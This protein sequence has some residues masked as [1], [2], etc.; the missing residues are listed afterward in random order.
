MQDWFESLIKE[1]F[2]ESL[3]DLYADIAS[4]ADDKIKEKLQGLGTKTEPLSSSPLIRVVGST[5]DTN[6]EVDTITLLIRGRIPLFK[7][8][9]SVFMRIELTIST[10][11]DIQN[12]DP[13]I[14]I[15]DWHTIIGDLKISKKNV[16]FANLGFGYNNDTWLGRGA[17]KII[18]AGFG[19]D[20]YLGGW[21]QQGVMIGFTMDYPVALPLGST[22]LGIKGVG[23]DFAY[24]FI[25][26]LEDS[27]VEVPNPTAEDYITW[28]RDD[29]PINRWQEGPI[30]DTSVGVG[31][32]AD[33][34]TLADQ[35]KALKLEPIGLMV[36]TP[37]PIFVLGGEGK[38]LEMQSAQVEGYIAVD[39]LS[40]SMALGLG[41]RFMMPPPKLGTK[42]KKGEKYIVDAQGT[43]D[44]FFSFAN[45]DAWYINLGSKEN[46][47]KAKT[48]VDIFRAQFYLMLNNY[49]VAVG[50]GISYGGQY[51]WWKITLTARIGGDVAA[52][53]GWN[54]VLFEGMLGIWAELG[55]KIWKFKFSL[56][57][58]V[59]VWGY[60][61]DPTRLEFVFKYKLDLP[62]PLPDY[63]GKK[64]YSIG[65]EDPKPPEI[66]SPLLAGESTVDNV[67]TQGALPI[68]L[69]HPLTGRQWEVG[70]EEEACWPDSVIVVPFSCRVV[71]ETPDKVVE[72]GLPISSPIEG[73][74]EVHHEMTALQVLHFPEGAEFGTPIEDLKAVWQAGP[75]GDIAQLHIGGTDPFSWVA[76]HPGVIDNTSETPPRVVEQNF[77]TG[78]PESF[79]SEKRFGEMIVEPIGE[80]DQLITDFYP[81]LPTRVMGGKNFKLKFKTHLNNPIEVEKIKL[82]FVCDPEHV[83]DISMQTGILEQQMVLKSI[84]GHLELRAKTFKVD[85]ASD[86]ISIH[87]LSDDPILLFSVRYQEADMVDCDLKDKLV[88]SP[89]TYQIKLAGESKAVYS[90]TDPDANLPD[91]SKVNWALSEVFNVEPPDTLRP[92]I[93]TTTIGD[94]RIFD[95]DSPPREPAWN[96]TM[97]GFGFP[98][99]QHYHPSVRFKVPYIDKIFQKIT[100]TIKYETGEEVKQQLT[101]K[102]NADGENYLPEMS[103][104]WIQDHCGKWEH[105]QEV[106]MN[107]AFTKAGPA[108][109]VLSVEDDLGNST[110]LDDWACIVSIFNGFGDHLKWK[111]KSISVF[112]GPN[113]KYIGS[114]CDLPQTKHYTI[115]RDKYLGN[116]I[117][118]II[119]LRE[120]DTKTEETVTG[121][122][123]KSNILQQIQVDRDLIITD[124]LE[125]I[126]NTEISEPRPEE[127]G[128]PLAAWQLS[129]SL[130]QHLCELDTFTGARYAHFALETG[131]WFNNGS[132]D[133]LDGINDTVGTT[134][135]EAIVDQHGRPYALWLRTPEPVDWRRVTSSLRIAHVKGSGACPD[136]YA[137]RYPLLLDVGILPSPDGSSAF[138]I[139][140]QAGYRTKLPKGI[141]TL[142]LKF[143]SKHSTLPNLK[144][145]S[146]IG[147][148]ET[149]I[150][151]FVQPAGLDW[152]LPK[153]DHVLPDIVFEFLEKENAGLI[154]IFESLWASELNQKK[155]M[156]LLLQSKELPEKLLQEKEIS[157]LTIK[158]I[159][160]RSI[161]KRLVIMAKS[162]P[163]TKIAIAARKI[164]RL[165][166]RT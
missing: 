130:T 96:P 95:I 122:Q 52:L 92:Y 20:L 63:E 46:Q 91:S 86:N 121:K 54:P 47:I 18:P 51:S 75:G 17:V 156:K 116:R 27:G 85:P 97:H 76:P 73:G 62:W 82:I 136:D 103:I 34:V 33:L 148:E 30:E 159:Q 69:L 126:K 127:L 1:I 66:S 78:D 6:G 152:P 153:K 25:P 32:S 22:G 123:R 56:R 58:A 59:E 15:I 28:A 74:Y 146:P 118:P 55:I 87:I 135:V 110:K 60:T 89:G 45:P 35:G 109:V 41:A 115:D 111:E 42:F 155:F 99:Y 161:E 112:Y 24:N 137:N 94:S 143:K 65:D 88:F 37:G 2:W 21:S 166:E 8:I 154:P 147:E 119:F 151:T 4:W 83:P 79:I 114:N 23:G 70:E 149:V 124:L 117:D 3:C 77:G 72:V 162:L 16:F 19:L 80:T 38:I 101:P 104:K 71:D 108:A 113:G 141:Y 44:A 134:S 131:V 29:E 31:I 11:V 61:K 107:P 150:L 120:Q 93:D 13:P 90:K 81:E 57:G 67:T 125:D 26:L 139:G 64:T 140:S 158:L 10:E 164:L 142:R 9:E 39:I 102:P 12:F 160:T 100:M 105:D 7:Y 133:P 128:K 68:G 145:I 138:L 48:F 129:S 49:R 157:R 53:I 40:Q 98:I 165:I 50:G 84:Y 36:L 14:E 163:R 5:T 132:N 43:L 106:V 144:P